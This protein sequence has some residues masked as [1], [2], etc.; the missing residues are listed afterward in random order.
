M[1]EIDQL[2]GTVFRAELNT[3]TQVDL[4]SED[5]ADNIPAVI[6]LRIDQE[7]N[8]LVAE[9]LCLVTQETDPTDVERVFADAFENN[10]PIAIHPHGDAGGSAVLTSVLSYSMP[11][12]NDDRIRGRLLIYQR[13]IGN[14]ALPLQSA[15][16]CIPDFPLFTGPGASTGI[17]TR[18][19]H[20]PNSYSWHRTGHVV[21][22]ADDWQI[23]LS[24]SNEAS[25]PDYSHDM[26]I[27]KNDRSPFTGSELSDLISK[28]SYFLTLVAGIGR[29]PSVVVGYDNAYPIWG[30]FHRFKQNPYTQ[31]NW[32]NPREGGSITALFP[33]FWTFLATAG[34]Q[35]TRPIELYAESSEIAHSGLHQHALTVSQS[36]LEHIAEWQLGPRPGNTNVGNHIDNALNQMGIDTD[37]SNFPDILAVWVRKFNGSPNDPGPTFVTRLRNSVHPRPSNSV[38]DSWDFYHAWRLSQ[39]YVETALLKLCGY[40]GRYRNRMTA[41][42]TTESEQVPWVPQKNTGDVTA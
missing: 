31:D 13:Q 34:E 28:F 11:I 24:Q 26:G 41:R 39:Y 38:A 9:Y 3:A 5:G 7:L 20:N 40:T 18:Y 42:W 6:T 17:E 22:E 16:A 2:F 35:L 8:Q 19:T 15:K 23:T 33:L 27:G 30:E 21:L 37:L 10:R 32:F 36:A 1:S 12:L 4:V 29:R 25:D 14:D